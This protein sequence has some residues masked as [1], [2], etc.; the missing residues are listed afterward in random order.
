MR[1]QPGYILLQAEDPE[2][3]QR[4]IR[5][6]SNPE[7]VWETSSSSPLPT[8]SPAGRRK[9]FIPGVGRGDKL[10]S[11]VSESLRL[12]GAIHQ[13]KEVGSPAAPLLCLLLVNLS[14]L[15]TKK[16]RSRP[17]A[18]PVKSMVQTRL[19]TLFLPRL[20]EGQPATSQASQPDWPT[21]GSQH[22]ADVSSPMS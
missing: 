10:A 2:G 6:S 5:Q 4:V 19:L 3:T 11:V 8:P 22:V 15:L 18:R 12:N 1:A 21:R 20:I 7:S 9:S 16:V 14:N 17:V 13:M